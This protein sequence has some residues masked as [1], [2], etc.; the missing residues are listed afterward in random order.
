MATSMDAVWA[1]GDITTFDGKLKL[2]ATG[3]AEAAVAVAQAVHHIRPEMKPPAEVLDQHRGARG[4]RGPGVARGAV[5][6]RHHPREWRGLSPSDLVPD[7]KGESGLP[8]TPSR[9]DP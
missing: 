2:I 6:R 7:A 5:A 3:F 4:G 1:A 8:C 9:F